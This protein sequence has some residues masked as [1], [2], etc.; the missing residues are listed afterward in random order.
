MSALL[1]RDVRL[2]VRAGS[3][4]GLAVAF[5][6][7]V[8]VLVPLGVGP[9]RAAMGRVAPGV[10]WIGVLLA[11]LLPLERV[12]TLDAHDGA[13]DLLAQSPVPLEAVA[14]SKALAHW[15]TTALP[16]VLVSPLFGL[17]LHMPFKATP[18]MVIS[19]GLGTPALSWIG[20]FGAALIVEVRHGGLLL[21]LL[22]LPLPHL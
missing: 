22:V 15:L 1:L 12:F 2:A 4:F 8:C 14:F 18:W 10:L 21:A 16:L 5:F 6:L 9:E 7:I 19:L 11:C 17:L 20:T 13:L 3:G